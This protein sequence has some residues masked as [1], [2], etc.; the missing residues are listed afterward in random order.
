[1]LRSLHC[2][3]VLMLLFCSS[4]MT[5]GHDATQLPVVL[6]GRAGGRLES[7]RVLDYEWSYRG[8]KDLLHAADVRGETAVFFGPGS[9]VPWD[10]WQLRRCFVVEQRP[11]LAE[12]RYGR[13]LVFV[14]AENSTI[15]LK[16]IF[17][18]SDDLLKVLYP[19]YQWP[20]VQGSLANAEPRETV[21]R[22]MANVA[23]NVQTGA[24]SMVWTD[25]IEIPDVKASHVRRLFSISNL[26][27]GH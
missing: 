18:R 12:H 7:G 26:N 24:S 19:L 14:D 21:L 6:M 10:R 11:H 2:L 4:M 13:S 15:A 16:L 17:D 1:M 25:S 3:S 22:F 27:A 9:H 5:G 20:V 8:E 23:I